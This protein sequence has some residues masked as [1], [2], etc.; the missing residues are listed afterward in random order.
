MMTK[1]LRFDEYALLMAPAP[2][3]TCGNDNW[4]HSDDCRFSIYWEWVAEAYK[5]YIK[6]YKKEVLHE[7]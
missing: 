7:D 4:H 6:K 5:E 3:C 2:K 1:K